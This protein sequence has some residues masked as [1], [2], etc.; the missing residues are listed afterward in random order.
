M[1]RLLRQTDRI[2][3]RNFKHK[4]IPEQQ[5]FRPYHLN[6][7]AYDDPQKGEHTNFKVQNIPKHAQFHHQ[8]LNLDE[9]EMISEGE[10]T[11]YETQEIPEPQRFHHRFVKLQEYDYP[12]KRD[13]RKY[14]E[15]NY[16]VFLSPIETYLGIL[17]KKFVLP[18][19]S[20]AS[21][22]RQIGILAGI[23]GIIIWAIS[24]LV[25]PLVI[26]VNGIHL[27][28]NIKYLMIYRYYIGN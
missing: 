18:Y 1:L 17:K 15:R 4:S 5:P 16:N 23:I 22:E 3:R 25:S 27:N 9:Y 28:I 11:S 10:F 19:I 21:T 26:S 24:P 12:E 7:D 2:K 6:V 20:K 13:F 8:H 14:K